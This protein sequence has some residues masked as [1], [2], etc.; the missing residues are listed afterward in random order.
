MRR[1]DMAYYPSYVEVEEVRSID[2]TIKVKAI[3]AYLF[4][5]IEAP[6]YDADARRDIMFVGGFSH[7][8][9]VDAVKWLAEE[10]LPALLKHDPDV[11]I[12]I[13]GS[14]APNEVKALANEHLI[15][16]G[17]V[18]DEQLEEFYRTSRISLVP[19]RYGA[20]IKGKVIES[21][22]YGT[23]VVTTSVGAE[24]IVD[25]EEVML[26]EDDGRVLAEKLAR[27][28]HDKEALARMSRDGVDYIQKNFS[29]QN[30]IEIIGDDFGLS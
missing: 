24:G 27:L 15:M 3:P 13:L 4:E 17:F 5:G 18:T 14:N 10:V 22:R 19:L 30:A 11:K 8:P 20:G 28:Y 29:P 23:P 21:L 1:A 25:A 26:V 6:N 7:R 12:H 16:E 2:P 9:N